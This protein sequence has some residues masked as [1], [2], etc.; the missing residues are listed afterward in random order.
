MNVAG[1]ERGSEGLAGLREQR[2][3]FG[4]EALLLVADFPIE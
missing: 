2:A 4:D 3:Y 1:F